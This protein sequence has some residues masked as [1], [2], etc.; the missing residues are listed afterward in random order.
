MRSSH[1]DLASA[2]LAVLALGREGD[3][4]FVCAVHVLVTTLELAAA[5]STHGLLNALI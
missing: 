5:L 4:S 3:G 1:S 2:A